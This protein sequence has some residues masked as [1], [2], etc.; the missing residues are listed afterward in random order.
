M[1]ITETWL[2]LFFGKVFVKQFEPKRTENN[3]PVILLH[4]SLGSVGLWKQFPEQL[5]EY[6]GRPVVAYDRI[7]FGLSSPLSEQPSF[8]FIQEEAEHYFPALKRAL[9]IES[10]WLFGIS[11]GGAMSLNIAALDDDCQGVITLGTASFMEEKTKEGIR[12]TEAFL[13]SLHT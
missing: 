8:T 9:G 11:V 1:K 12:A 10:Y 6:L 5:A 13:K 3:E 2:E 7:G 4:D